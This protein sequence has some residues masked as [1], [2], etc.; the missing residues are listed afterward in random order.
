MRRD[1]LQT[2]SLAASLHYVPHDILRDALS[3]HLSR[4]GH[5]SKDSSL[6]DLGC[7]YPL[8][9]CRFDPS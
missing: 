9:E 8:I 7:Y 2:R 5:C 1:M 6:R 3:P 4:S